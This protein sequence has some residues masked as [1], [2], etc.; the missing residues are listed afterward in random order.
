[1]QDTLDSTRAQKAATTEQL[2]SAKRNFEV[3]TQTI[4]DTHEA[5]A[6]YDL[7]VAQ[8]FAAR[9][10]PGKQ[11]EPRCR[12]II[13]AA[14]ALLAPLTLRRHADAPAAEHD[15]PVGVGGRKPELQRAGV[16]SW[17]SNRPSAKLSATAPGIC[18]RSTWWPTRSIPR[19]TA[20]PPVGQHDHE[21]RDRGAME[22]ADL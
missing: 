4:T 3:G 10:R 20:R 5:Q 1:M 2:A 17:R 18:R 11:E 9:E 8:E 14:P 15:R 21:Q 7:V 13:G 19:S 12:P 6:A 22:R 16:A